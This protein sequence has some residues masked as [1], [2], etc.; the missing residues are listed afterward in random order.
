MAGI[1]DV[2]YDLW[3]SQD[4]VGEMAHRDAIPREIRQVGVFWLVRHFGVTD[5]WGATRD[6]RERRERMK[7]SS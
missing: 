5:S 7:Q 4:R 1:Y 6:G 2:I 3:S